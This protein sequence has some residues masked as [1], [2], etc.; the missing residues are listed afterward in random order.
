MAK[1]KQE[2][3]IA[4][5][6]TTEIVPAHLVSD[7]TEEQS[8]HIDTF[9]LNPRQRMFCELYSSDK[10]FFGNGVQTY[11]E[12]YEP[13]STKPNWYKSACASASQILSNIKV[14]EC[15][16]YLMELRGL[17]D[18]FVDKQLEFLITQHTDFKSKLGA[19]REYNSLKKRTEQGGN[20]TL[21][22]V[23]SGETAN[24]YGVVPTT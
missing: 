14:C 3:A 17:N 16:N 13:D 6:D 2:S 9:G 20:K 19:I 23:V 24:R 8:Q 18:T 7:L 1:R 21:V 12:V 5:V 10:E 15:I 11:I 4:E 22:L